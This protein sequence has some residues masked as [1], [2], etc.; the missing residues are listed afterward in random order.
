MVDRF[1]TTRWNIVRSAGRSG[2]GAREALAN[3][4]RTY[5]PPVFAYV[6]TLVKSKEDAEDLTQAFF[7]HLLEHRLAARADRERGR[8][9]CF[10]LTSLKHF[11]CSERERAGAHRRGGHSTRLSSSAIDFIAEKGPGPEQAFDRE[12]ARDVLR[13]ATRRLSEEARTAGRTKMFAALQPY[14]GEA[15]LAGDYDT[16]AKT[17]GIRRNTVAVT[18]HR[19]RRR[20]KEIVTEVVAGMADGRIAR[21]LAF[22]SSGA[23]DVDLSDPM[24]RNL[25]DYELLEK[26]GSGGTSVVYRARQ[27]SLD[28]EVA[29]KLLTVG[30]RAP[31][32]LIAR[33]RQEADL[34]TRLKHPNIV[35]VYESGRQRDLSYFSMSLVSGESLAKRLAREGSFPPRQA[36]RLL[37]IVAD[38]IAYAHRRGVLHLDLKPGNVLIDKRGVPHV[39]DFG[40]ARRKHALAGTAGDASGTPSYMAPEQ[41]EDASHRIGRATDVFGL[42]AI[43]YELL[44]NRPPFIACTPEAT[45]ERVLDDEVV[46][47]RQHDP[48][49]P[50]DIEAICLRCLQKDPVER[51]GSASDLSD[52]LRVILNA[53]LASHDHAWV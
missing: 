20:L 9:R 17:L 45:L 10:L 46:P 44:C 47:P 4:C 22:Q 37:R 50:S 24:P 32:Q 8:F 23:L 51:Y 33:F 6:R 41:V 28:R 19:L 12:W 5:H 3:L 52:D 29:L 35:T 16:L 40:L 13:E 38:A 49:I 34:G 18:V 26:I 48:S 21:T 15:P 14:L 27:R 11:L 31:R 25:G 7:V 1:E 36:A 39:A 43:L 53:G 42:G 2:D 30:P